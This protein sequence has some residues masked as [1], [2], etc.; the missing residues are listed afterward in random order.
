M[1]RMTSLWEFYG[2]IIVLTF[3]MSFGTFIIFVAVVGNWFQKNRGKALSIL[4]AGAGLGGITIPLI[5]LGIDTFG[6][7]DMLLCIGVGF[8]IIGFPTSLVLRW[9]PEDLSLIHI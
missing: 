4:M 2:S 7:R 5:V 6:W 9:N 8:W 1:S 3:G